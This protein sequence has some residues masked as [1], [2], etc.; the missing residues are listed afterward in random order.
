LAV[1]DLNNLQNSLRIAEF[2]SR[3]ATATLKDAMQTLSKTQIKSPISGI[4]LDVYMKK[5]EKVVGTGQ[6]SGTVIMG[7]ADVKELEVTTLIN[8]ND[9]NRVHKGQKAKIHIDAVHGL[10]LGGSVLTVSTINKDK[11]TAD[12][13]TEYESRIKF[14]PTNM[15]KNMQELR[16]GMTATVDIVT[17]SKRDR[18]LVPIQTVLFKTDSTDPNPDGTFNDFEYVLRYKKGKAEIAKV[19]T[20]ISNSS[21]I[22]ILSGLSLKDTVLSGPYDVIIGPKVLKERLKIDKKSI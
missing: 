7:L 5:G 2:N 19:K 15:P 4:V 14:D 3:S 22:E 20:G 16:L 8:E 17:N 11:T 13:V 12:A 18:L 9:I 1:K 10:S 21:L 6:M